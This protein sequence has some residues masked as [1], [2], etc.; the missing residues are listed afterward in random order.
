MWRPNRVRFAL[1]G[2]GGVAW[3][4]TE[5]G[6]A[7]PPNVRS[8]RMAVLARDPMP[9]MPVSSELYLS[10][11]NKATPTRELAANTTAVSPHA[12]T[13]PATWRPL[14]LFAQV[15]PVCAATEPPKLEMTATEPHQRSFMAVE[16]HDWT[17]GGIEAA[18]VGQVCKALAAEKKS[19]PVGSAVT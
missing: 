6:W 13:P 12:W 11:S 7:A 1:A 5:M 18:A 2:P 17:G 14:A 16:N 15:K 19:E 10:H 3:S 8:K 4:F 9:V